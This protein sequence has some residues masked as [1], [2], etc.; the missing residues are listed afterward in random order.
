MLGYSWIGGCD[1]M[2][3]CQ[4]CGPGLGEVGDFRMEYVL[5]SPWH[6]H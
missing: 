4:C 3:W 5:V 2:N 6:R 1:A